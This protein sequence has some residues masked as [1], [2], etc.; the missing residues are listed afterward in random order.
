MIAVA[1][2]LRWASYCC[3]R[4]GQRR[5]ERRWIRC[6]WTLSALLVVD[7]MIKSAEL[8]SD[9]VAFRLVFEARK[10][11]ETGLKVR[12]RDYVLGARDE[13]QR[14]IALLESEHGRQETRDQG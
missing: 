6:G 11:I 9:P 14:A 10:L 7:T 2:H 12:K 4:G 8:R 13:L 5:C 3:L 1:E